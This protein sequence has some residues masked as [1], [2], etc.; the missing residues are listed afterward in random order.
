MDASRHIEGSQFL[1]KGYRGSRLG[2]DFSNL[3]ARSE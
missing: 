1:H 2:R 3:K